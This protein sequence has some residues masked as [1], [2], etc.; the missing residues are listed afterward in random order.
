MTNIKHFRKEVKVEMGMKG[1]EIH[2]K[3]KDKNESVRKDVIVRIAFLI[4]MP[5][6]NTAK[7]IYKNEIFIINK[8]IK[9]LS[10]L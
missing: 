5:F 9:S 7:K 2:I 3:A 1:K 8:T 10:V 4:V 6:F